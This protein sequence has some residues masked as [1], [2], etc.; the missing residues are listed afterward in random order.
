MSVIETY[1]QLSW[2]RLI[3]QLIV[4]LPEA[5]IVYRL[6]TVSEAPASG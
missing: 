1:R 6:I 4:K 3:V 5:L 2:N